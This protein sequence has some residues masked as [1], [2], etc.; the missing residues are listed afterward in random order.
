[1][2]KKVSIRQV[3]EH[4]GVSVATVSLALSGKGRI[5]SDT[6][7]QV[8]KSAATLGFIPNRSA[9]RLRSGRSLLI[10]LVVN[11][12]ANPFFAELSADVEAHASE[13]G[14]LSVIA[15]TNDDIE[16]QASVI[17]TMI[18]QGVAGFIIVPA[19]TSTPDT[20]QVIRDHDMPYVLC[21]R[22]IGDGKADFIGFDNFTAGVMAAEHLVEKGHRTFAFVGGRLSVDNF[23]RRLD[24]VRHALAR[25]GLTLPDNCVREGVPSR[26][27][28]LAE[29]GDLLAS[30]AEFTALICYNDF[31][32]VGAYAALNQAGRTIGEDVAV[33]GFD[34]V[35]ESESLS[36]PLTTIELYPRAIGNRSARALIDAVNGSS[37]PHERVYLAPE[38]IS[39]SST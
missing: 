17:E 25:H 5:S 8:K 9:S 13:N 23:R 2:G 18:G 15:N 30:G 7:R 36:P 1:M 32:A 6:V 20:F 35:P 19:D 27:I 34:N 39:R 37:G 29:T 28:G 26:A 3:A 11:D 24:G 12:I 38:L 4:A 33:V 10:G 22:D 16:K 31:V 14:Y 21:V